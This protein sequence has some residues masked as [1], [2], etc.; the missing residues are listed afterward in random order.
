M[1][2]TSSLSAKNGITVKRFRGTRFRIPGLS[3][4]IEGISTGPPDRLGETLCEEVGGGE[5]ADL[6]GDGAI[7]TSLARPRAVRWRSGLLFR[8]LAIG[9]GLLPLLA[10]EVI[11]RAFDLGRPGA[12]DDP[13]VGFSAVRPLFEK[14]KEG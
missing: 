8:V 9:I 3:F 14:N 10:S 12:Y 13:F 1:A 7:G 6:S 2:C 4:S 5:V 11:L